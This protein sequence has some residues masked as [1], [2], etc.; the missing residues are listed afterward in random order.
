MQAKQQK[1]NVN[2]FRLLSSEQR[3]MY[4]NLKMYVYVCIETICAQN[5]HT[6]VYELVGVLYKQNNSET[7]KKKLKISHS[8]TQIMPKIKNKK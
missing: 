6:Y 1:H 5:T 3:N 2:A 4:N 7:N 8:N